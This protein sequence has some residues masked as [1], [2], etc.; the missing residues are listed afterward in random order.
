MLVFC[1]HG[2]GIA[3]DGEDMFLELRCPAAG[4]DLLVLSGRYICDEGTGTRNDDG[5]CVGT[6]TV[7]MRGVD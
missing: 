6:E 5:R 3:R 1:I 7:L 2:R 4:F